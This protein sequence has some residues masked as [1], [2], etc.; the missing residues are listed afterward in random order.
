MDEVTSESVVTTIDNMLDRR[1]IESATNQIQG[2]MQEVV[3][4]NSQKEGHGEVAHERIMKDLEQ[5]IKDAKTSLESIE[6]FH[7][8]GKRQLEKIQGAYNLKVEEKK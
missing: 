7:T 4:I 2:E 6:Q 5:K 8:K 3:N 1:Q